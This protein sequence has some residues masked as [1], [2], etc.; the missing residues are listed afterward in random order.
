MAHDNVRLSIPFDALLDSVAE[1][2]LREKLRLWRLL[3]EQLAQVEED[4]WEQDPT[5]QADIR[6]ARSA[7][8]AGDYVTID[9]YIAQR[10]EKAE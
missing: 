1:L 3:D 4:S 8:K 6:E 5:V 2:S 10:R 7:Y 9:E